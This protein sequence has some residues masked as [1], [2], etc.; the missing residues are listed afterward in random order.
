MKGDLDRRVKREAKVLRENT[1]GKAW[2]VYQGQQGRM[3][4]LVQMAEMGLKERK[5]TPI[6]DLL[7]SKEQR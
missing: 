6:L 3:D 5:V 2:A 1:E 7:D 4:S